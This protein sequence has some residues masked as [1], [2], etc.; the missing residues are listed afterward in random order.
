MAL[1]VSSSWT[2]T[3]MVGP[4]SHLFA[5]TGPGTTT[6]RTLFRPLL[7]EEYAVRKRGLPHAEHLFALRKCLQSSVSTPPAVFHCFFL[8]FVV[9][10]FLPIKQFFCIFLHINKLF[11]IFYIDYFLHELLF[12]FFTLIIFLYS[13]YI[14]NFYSSLL[15]I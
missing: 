3:K 2:S 1:R 11:C 12:V 14:V 5:R 7:R 8:F 13:F 6:L 9:L 10:F 4:Y 15:L